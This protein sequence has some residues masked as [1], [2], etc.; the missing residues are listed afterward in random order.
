MG[1]FYLKIRTQILISRGLFHIL[2][3]I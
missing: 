3:I 2:N 1:M